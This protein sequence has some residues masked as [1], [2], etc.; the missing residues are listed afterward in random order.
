MAKLTDE[1]I[2]VHVIGDA[3]I[4]HVKACRKVAAARKRSAAAD[5]ALEQADAECSAAGAELLDARAE[6]REANERRIRE[7]A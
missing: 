6:L 7:L 3:E 2:I 1:R 4:Q 5:R